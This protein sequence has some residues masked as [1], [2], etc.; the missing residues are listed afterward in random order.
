MRPTVPRHTGQ[1]IGLETPTR[2]RHRYIHRG[3]RDHPTIHRRPTGIDHSAELSHGRGMSEFDLDRDATPLVSEVGRALR[4]ARKQRGLSQREFA[5][6]LGIS[7]SRLARLESDAGPQSLEM[8]CQVLMASGFRLKVIDPE[9]IE[10]EVIDPEVIE[11]EVIAGSGAEAEEA[12]ALA[13]TVVELFD[14]GGRHFPAHLDAYPLAYP[15]LYWFV[16]NGGWITSTP[17][18]QW[19]YERRFVPRVASPGRRSGW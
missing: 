5:Q 11:T 3:P 2:A 16:R 6:Q 12:G 14:A 7:K 1:S 15:P 9:A 18:P 8:V 13:A 17:Y 4:K 10:T 19:T